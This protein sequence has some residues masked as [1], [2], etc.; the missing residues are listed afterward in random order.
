MLDLGM[1]YERVFQRCPKYLGLQV[2]MGIGC[3]SLLSGF[4]LS[5]SICLWELEM[6]SLIHRL[7][8]M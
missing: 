8:F 1:H 7:F 3:P 5:V 2:L 4:V 6:N